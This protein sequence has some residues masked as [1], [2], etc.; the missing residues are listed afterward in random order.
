[1]SFQEIPNHPRS[2]LYLAKRLPINPSSSFLLSFNLPPP[3]S[4][5]PSTA[6]PPTSSF[7][8]PPSPPPLL[9][10]PSPLPSPPHS[11]YD[12][13][14]PSSIFKN[15]TYSLSSFLFGGPRTDKSGKL[16]KYSIIGNPE[17]FVQLENIRNAQKRTNSPMRRNIRR[18]LTKKSI[19]TSF[20]SNWKRDEEEGGGGGGGRG[21]GGEEEEGRRMDQDFT[22]KSEGRTGGDEEGGRRTEGEWGRKRDEEEGGQGG[23]GGEG[24]R[25]GGGGGV[26]GSRKVMWGTII[27]SKYISNL[28]SFV[29]ISRRQVE[30]EMEEA[31]RRVEEVRRTDEMRREGLKGEEKRW[32]RKEE[33]L[34][35]KEEERDT[36]W[37]KEGE[38]ISNKVQITLGD[39][40]TIAYLILSSTINLLYYF[41]SFR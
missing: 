29:R 17:K 30:R 23:R 2:K 40:Y 37:E 26:G 15:P 19:K 35:K 10:P 28:D 14:F 5:P 9:L 32:M 38:K 7:P 11:S 39:Q 4:L 34:R 25:G 22:Q 21:G 6:L 24:E 31:R 8:S 16:V 13:C 12:T 20:N 27:N 41:G 1:M 36:Q 33:I 18:L 3:S